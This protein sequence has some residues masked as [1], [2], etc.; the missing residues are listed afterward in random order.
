M[1]QDLELV[2]FSLYSV[3]ILSRTTRNLIKDSQARS[4]AGLGKQADKRKRDARTD[5]EIHLWRNIRDMAETMAEWDLKPTDI[6]PTW[7]KR[8]QNP[9]G[10]SSKRAG[11]GMVDRRDPSRE[12]ISGSKMAVPTARIQEI[13]PQARG[14]RSEAVKPVKTDAIDGGTGALPLTTTRTSATTTEIEVEGPVPTP[15]ASSGLSILSRSKA[16]VAFSS[17][18][19]PPNTLNILARSKQHI[20][21]NT[22]TVTT[23]SVAAGLSIRSHANKPNKSAQIDIDEPAGQARAQVPISK[24]QSN[25]LS[26]RSAAV[27]SQNKSNET[28]GS[29]SLLS[30]IGSGTKRPRE[31]PSTPVSTSTPVAQG[32]R[33]LA[34]RLNAPPNSSDPIATT[35]TVNGNKKLRTDDTSYG[36]MKSGAPSLLSRMSSG[37]SHNGNGVQRV[38]ASSSTP[39]SN[40]QPHSTNPNIGFTFKRT[41]LLNTTQSDL[42][43]GTPTAITN[44][45][46]PRSAASQVPI[47]S[48]SI[49]NRASQSDSTQDGGEP[50][51]APDG[52]D[53]IIRKGRGFA[54][55]QIGIGHLGQ[56]GGVRGFGAERVGV[57][58]CF[59]SDRQ[60]I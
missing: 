26:I 16:P 17:T 54:A 31:E 30:R 19:P 45:A 47:P 6:E 37:T 53:G 33:S 10:E 22:A 59:D 51:V 25:G 29:G 39:R 55:S 38:T 3:V 44:L 9:Q 60:G 8:A 28:P 1:A 42:T 46:V 48:F 15:T 41:G 21:S 34:D 18:Q 43:P 14:E 2:L 27:Q 23:P 4:L 13:V 32:S 5:D 20:T 35:T 40:T 56:P 7:I 52:G 57:G 58:N 36:G 49:K 24:T 11:S 12:T 50:T